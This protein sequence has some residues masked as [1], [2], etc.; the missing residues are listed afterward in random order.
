MSK[1]QLKT[2]VNRHQIAKYCK[3]IQFQLKIKNKIIKYIK[4]NLYKT[5]IS[6]FF[7]IYIF[8]IYY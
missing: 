5:K 2:T 1:M 7:K 4:N 6:Y 3:Y 8:F